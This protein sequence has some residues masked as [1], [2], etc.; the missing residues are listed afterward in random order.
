MAVHPPEC[1]LFFVLG[2][3]DVYPLRRK[4]EPPPRQPNPKWAECRTCG[5]ES[6][7]LYWITP[8]SQIIIRPPHKPL[9]AECWEREL[10]TSGSKY[11]NQNHSED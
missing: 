3:L 9:C 5:R 1:R 6:G 11:T 7:D 8:V 10:R 2:P 4:F